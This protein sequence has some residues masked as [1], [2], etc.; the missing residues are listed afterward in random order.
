MSNFKD[1][2]TALRSAIPDNLVLSDPQ[3][4]SF[5]GK[6]W[7]KDFT[8]APSLV[9]LPETTD[10]VQEIVRL[11]NQ[12]NV[13]LVPSGGRTGLSGGATATKGEIILSV[14]RM[15]KIIEI[16]RAERTIRC[17]AGVVLEQI[18]MAAA[19]ADLYFP[20]DFSSRGSAQIGGN[21]ATNAGGIRVIKYGNFRQSV[22][23]LTVITGAGQRL[24]LNGSLFKN[25]SG[26]DL[27]NLFIGSE[28]TLG[29]IVE[30]TL[31]LTTQPKDYVRALCGLPSLDSVLP[32]LTFCRDTLPNVS[33]FELMES[34][35]YQEVIKRRGLRNPLESD[36]PAYIIMECEVPSEASRQ[37]IFERFGEAYET[38]LI[39]DVVVSESAAQAQEIMNI[40]DLVSETLSQHYTLHKNDISVPVSAVPSFLRELHQT[41][42]STYPSFRVAVF[43]HV[44]D[45][46]L[47]VNVLKS[48]EM[49]D[50]DFWT[51]CHEADHAVFR[52]VKSFR[53]S[54]SAEHGVGLLKRDFLN[55]T[56]SPEEID[57][58]RGIK[59]VFDPRGIMNPGKIFSPT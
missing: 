31:T 46:N 49:S 39:S 50:A 18:Q 23:G 34:L 10:H 26:Y 40:R 8:P 13:A 15:R 14:E 52:L 33:A 21:I 59:A 28:G 41:I 7:L 19:A 35:P 36:H 48:E 56:R 43:G 16:N 20:V 4:L 58:M 37:E 42:Q 51:Q 57:I 32:L 11:C 54:V 25:N 53:G 47:H 44:G 38:G 22:L 1:L 24:E 30:A 55:Y 27:R 9:V 45:G 6:D 2:Q 17:Q 3:S 29:I 5:Y 12:H